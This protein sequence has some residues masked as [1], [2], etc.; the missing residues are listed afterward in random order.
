MENRSAKLFII[1]AIFWFSNFSGSTL[2]FNSRGEAFGG[3][4]A[5][6]AK[7]SLPGAHIIKGIDQHKQINGLGCGP[8]SLEILFDFWGPDVDQKAIADVARTSSI[9]TYTW[10]IVRTGQ[11]SYLSA[12]QGNFF[13][14]AAP[15]AGFPPRRLGYASF[16]HSS[17]AF[18]WDD[19]K[20]LIAADVPV[21]LLMKYSPDDPKGHYRVIVGYDEYKGVVYFMDPWDR[22][23]GKVTNP[24]GTV[25]WTMSDFQTC[26]DYAGYGTA[27]PHWGAIIVPWSVSL[28]TTGG[29][30]AGSVLKVT[31]VITYSC[32]RPFDYLSY[33]AS[34]AYAEIRLPV[35][36]H[37]QRGSVRVSVGN[38]LA[39][40]SFVVSWVVHLDTDGTEATI[41]VSTGGRVSG[42][43]PEANWRGNG[44]SYPPYNYADEIGGKAVIK[45]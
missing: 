36:M 17:D 25:T 41:A 39:G 22:D 31:A 34:D 8:A 12:A 32:P 23:L 7:S 38:L 18:W 11:F 45:L 27:N 5:A 29:K 9:G 28:Q 10:D 2:P 20:A 43:V 35:G 13:P 26:W 14:G 42:A 16:S 24:D 3:I 4:E 19:L 1:L 6:T 30:A 15:T 33:P 21:V 37:L 40:R 44:V